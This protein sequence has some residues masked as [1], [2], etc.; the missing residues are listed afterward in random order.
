[1][2][3]PAI[4]PRRP[5]PVGRMEDF[6]A[7]NRLVMVALAILR[8][9]ISVLFGFVRQEIWREGLSRQNIAAMPLIGND[10]S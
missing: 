9:I 1:M 2:G 10:S 5:Q 6:P 7:H 8:P 3:F 4:A